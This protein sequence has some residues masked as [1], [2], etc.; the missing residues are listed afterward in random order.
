LGRVLYFYARQSR[1]NF[2]KERYVIAEEIK[3][4][5]FN[6]ATIVKET[7]LKV[8][9]NKDINPNWVANTGKSLDEVV[10]SIVMQFG[11]DASQVFETILNVVQNPSIKEY[12]E[13]LAPSADMLTEEEF[14]SL[15]EKEKI[16]LIKQAKEC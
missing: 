5:K 16:E 9:T 8:G 6:K 11:Y 3:G 7:G 13:K 12:L 14:N 4:V 2:C 15:T 10:N 1:V